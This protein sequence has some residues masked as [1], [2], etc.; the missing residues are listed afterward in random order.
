MPTYE[1]DG[2]TASELDTK[3]VNVSGDT[4]TGD[5]SITRDASTDSVL[6]M[7]GI[8]ALQ[9]SY[10][11]VGQE[12]ADNDYF[13][14]I[15]RWKTRRSNA[16][17]D[18]SRY[19]AAGVK[20]A[21]SLKIDISTG[22][23][24]LE[25][26]P[27]SNLGAAT[28]GYVDTADNLKL[29]LTGGELSGQLRVNGGAEA[30]QLKAGATNDHVYMGL[31]ADS[32]NQATRTGY[33]GVGAAGS[34]DITLN[35]Q[36]TNGNIY[37]TTNGTGR[38]VLSADPT[39]AM[40]AATKQYAD[41]KVA[42]TGDTMSGDLLVT[43]STEPLGVSN[44]TQAS[45][46]PVYFAPR[47]SGGNVVG[48]IVR[49]S[50]SLA[51][52]P[53]IVGE[54]EQTNHAATQ[55]YVDAADVLKL[56][57]TGGALSGAVVNDTN[58]I[59][60]LRGAKIGR[61]SGGASVTGYLLIELPW[62]MTTSM[63]NIRIH[64]YNYV[65]GDGGFDIHIGGYLYA[66]NP[67]AAWINYSVDHTG[68]ERAP[69]QAVRLLVKGGTGSN[70][71]QYAIALGDAGTVWTY[72]QINVYADA[73]FSAV[74]AYNALAAPAIITTTTDISTW[75]SATP[76]VNNNALTVS[77][78]AVHTGRNNLANQIVRTDASGYLQVGYVNSSNGNEGNNSKPARIWGTNGSDDYMRSYLSSNVAGM[79]SQTGGATYAS[80]WNAYAL[81]F[82]KTGNIV[83][84]FFQARCTSAATYSSGTLH[85][86]I[87]AMPA[88]WAPAVNSFG[89]GLAQPGFVSVRCDVGTG[90][91]IGMYINSAASV[92][93]AVDQWMMVN[94]T[95]QAATP[96]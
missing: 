46:T 49:K 65:A 74:G 95:W 87:T 91:T 92:T 28:K 60:A 84:C 50:P 37:L 10:A 8:R 75:T 23:V 61:Y 30:L 42:K 41:L 34:A 88:G 71:Q 54:P 4:M 3:Y 17:F 67:T 40:H 68:L 2:A 77:G 1:I 73:G 81:Q 9:N 43:G 16:W 24:Y 72:P 94:M 83:S 76:T 51:Y 45:G 63:A 26:S 14:G 57:L 19:D 70:D 69:S 47:T 36:A 56:S 64:G 39:A 82:T 93:F 80:G 86:L 29:N 12:I 89:H 96:A 55:S 27:V 78:L 85:P 18:I 79:T 62:G 66:G 32:Q 31:Y 90:G 6:N 33:F 7:T 13:D 53:L 11:V 59:T 20:I 38:V 21:D 15:R 22:L 48:A 44:P 52:A 58:T 5:L 25:G 35:N